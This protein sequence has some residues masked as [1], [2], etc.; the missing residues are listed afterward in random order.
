MKNLW[1]SPIAGKFVQNSGIKHRWNL[2]RL[3]SK[4]LLEVSWGRN[5]ANHRQKKADRG[6]SGA[7]FGPSVFALLKVDFAV[8]PGY[9]R[10]TMNKMLLPTDVVGGTF[11][12]LSIA[13]IGATIFADTE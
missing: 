13:M 8:C 5:L 12:L 4:R 7:F 2:A 1:A 11:W 3:I 10:E 9:E 6:I